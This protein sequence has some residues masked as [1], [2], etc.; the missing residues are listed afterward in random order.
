[1]DQAIDEAREAGRRKWR[2]AVISLNVVFV[3]S[4]ALSFCWESVFGTQSQAGNFGGAVIGVAFMVSWLL[5]LIGVPWL[6]GTV[7]RPAVVGWA[8]AFL[9]LVFE[10]AFPK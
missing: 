3:C 10:M 6:V 5:L 9:L 2:K 1:M 8:L 7:G 4:A